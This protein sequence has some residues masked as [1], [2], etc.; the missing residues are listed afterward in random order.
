MKQATTAVADAGI[1]PAN[2]YFFLNGA[3][4]GAASLGVVL[5][6]LYLCGAR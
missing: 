2:I 3:C 6:A 5:L 1:T 4:L